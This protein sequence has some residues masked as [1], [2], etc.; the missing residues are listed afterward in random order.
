MAQ[1][2]QSSGGSDGSG[3]GSNSATL[4]SRSGEGAFSV[5]GGLK[6]SQWTWAALLI[7]AAL[8]VFAWLSRK[9]K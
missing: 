7:A 4:A 5:G 8:L 2:D 6:V 1:Q 3:S 9:K